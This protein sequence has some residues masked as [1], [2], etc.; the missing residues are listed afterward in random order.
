MA[1]GLLKV[2][3]QN[4]P[5]V[6]FCGNGNSG[7]M[8]IQIKLEKSFFESVFYDQAQERDNEKAVLAQG[9]HAMP[10]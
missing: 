7:K 9:N 2:L 6:L 5:N 10:L 3:L 8:S 4:F 1:S